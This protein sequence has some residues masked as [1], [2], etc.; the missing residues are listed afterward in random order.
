[1]TVST[2]SSSTT[3]AKQC[4]TPPKGDHPLATVGILAQ[5]PCD[6]AANLN[7]H[8]GLAKCGSAVEGASR[9]RSREAARMADKKVAIQVCPKD[10][11]TR[12]PAGS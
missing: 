9:P 8:S 1:M 3:Y 12:A 10:R 11:L 2:T 6:V 5:T 7:L 4:S